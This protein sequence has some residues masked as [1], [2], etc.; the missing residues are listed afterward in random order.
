MFR[1]RDSQSTPPKLHEVRLVHPQGWYAN[2]VVQT[3]TM[4][5]VVPARRF[6]LSESPCT[7]YVHQL[8]SVGVVLLVGCYTVLRWPRPAAHGSRGPHLCLPEFSV[9]SGSPRQQRL[10]L[11]GVVEN[12]N[13]RL[14]SGTLRYVVSVTGLRGPAAMSAALPL[15][16][17]MG[18]YTTAPHC[19]SCQL[20]W[21][22]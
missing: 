10:V 14:Q 3:T 7:R 17:D 6:S 12:D 16:Y 1:L 5:Q 21:Q 4:C 2:V 18:T 19:A 9:P 22:R 13:E 8:C 15:L 11:P 20:R